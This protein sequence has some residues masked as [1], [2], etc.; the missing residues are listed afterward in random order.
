M[1]TLIHIPVDVIIIIRSSNSKSAWHSKET[2]SG[3]PFTLATANS[4]VAAVRMLAGQKAQFL[5]TPSG[6][7][8]T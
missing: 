2:L 6:S 8:A 5:L 3:T 4:L 7:W 1:H